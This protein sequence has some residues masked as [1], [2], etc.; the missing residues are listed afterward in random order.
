MG[1]STADVY[2]VATCY[3]YFFLSLPISS[4]L[5]LLVLSLPIPSYKTKTPRHSP[6]GPTIERSQM[7]PYH[8]YPNLMSEGVRCGLD[9]EIGLDGTYLAY[10]PFSLTIERS[11][12]TPYHTYPNLMSEGVRCGL[13]KEV[14]LDGTYLT[15]FPFSPTIERPQ[16]APYHIKFS[17]SWHHSSG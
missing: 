9:K 15:Y 6:R 4:Y 14:G 16:I 8:T 7:T 17:S 13:D 1:I 5:V 11:Q 12:M 2:P 10:F 3:P